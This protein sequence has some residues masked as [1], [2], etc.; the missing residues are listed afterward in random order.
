MVPTGLRIYGEYG[1]AQLARA[2]HDLKALVQSYGPDRTVGFFADIY[3]TAL[4]PFV[5]PSA[6]GPQ[7]HRSIFVNRSKLL[8]KITLLTHL[9]QGFP[10]AIRH[11]P[12]SPASSLLSYRSHTSSIAGFDNDFLCFAEY[13]TS[14]HGAKL[15]A[16]K[17]SSE[18]RFSST[19]GHAPDFVLTFDSL[20]KLGNAIGLTDAEKLELLIRKKR[21]GLFGEEVVL[22]SATPARGRRLLR[23]AEERCLIFPE[24][25]SYIPFLG[26]S[27]CVHLPIAEWKAG[28]WKTEFEVTSSDFPNTCIHWQGDEN[29]QEKIESAFRVESFYPKKPTSHR[30]VPK[31]GRFLIS[32]PRVIIR[33]PSAVLLADNFLEIANNSYSRS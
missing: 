26:K 7:L 29:V 8:L 33:G 27:F 18:R 19:R 30:T 2:L 9:R 3:R 24:V 5:I 13:A 11:A 22:T 15:T 10:P 32:V 21:L 12:M 31:L 14:S 6:R 1:R 23:G 16:R 4:I 17:F 25:D 20:H 28:D